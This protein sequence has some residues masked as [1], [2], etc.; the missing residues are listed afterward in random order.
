[1]NNYKLSRKKI[2]KRII[3]IILCTALLLCGI[4]YHVTGNVLGFFN[5]Y[6]VYMGT[7]KLYVNEVP[8]E[9]IYEGMLKGMVEAVGDKYSTFLN[10]EDYQSLQEQTQGEFVGVGMV[11]SI[12]DNLPVVKELIKGQPAEKAGLLIGDKII[13]VDGKKT[14]GL[15]SKTIRNLIRGEKDTV[16]TFLIN[17]DGEEKTLEIKR[18][19]I[20]LPMVE[21]KMLEDKIGYIYISTFGTEIR[22]EFPAAYNKLNQEGMKALILDLRGNPGGILEESV[23]VANY[24]VPK[25]VV[26]T[27]KT[28]YSKPEVYHSEGIGKE[29]PLIVLVNNNS[30]SASELLAAAIQ[31]TKSGI[32]LGEKTY[33]KGTVQRVFPLQGGVAFK[34]TISKYLTPNNKEIDQ[35]GV[36]PDV[37][38]PMNVVDGKVVGDN[39][40]QEAIK[41]LQSKI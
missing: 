10:A 36:I 41:I 16:V 3:E 33:G 35:V 23:L 2:L 15:D 22:K 9:K 29:I 25:G 7:T 20:E 40:L 38:V 13:A 8:K 28:R 14:E 37:E 26:T 12:E 11:Y 21:S 19:K 4:S 1:M 34:I 31:D 17:R 32:I 39:Q 18:D 30:A 6:C 5:I 27:V 24:L